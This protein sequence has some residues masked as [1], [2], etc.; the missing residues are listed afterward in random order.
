[1]FETLALTIDK[2]VRIK[3]RSC[4]YNVFITL[5]I[6]EESNCDTDRLI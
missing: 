5:P 3:I 1:M 2:Y 6:G 4:D